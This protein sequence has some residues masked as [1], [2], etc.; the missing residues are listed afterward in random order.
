MATEL[1]STGVVGF[2]TATGGVTVGVLLPP[3]PPPPPQALKA[4]ATATSKHRV[5]GVD[6]GAPLRDRELAG[7]RDG[8]D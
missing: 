2:C 6:A 3:P 8:M 4:R 1:A 7:K 5:D